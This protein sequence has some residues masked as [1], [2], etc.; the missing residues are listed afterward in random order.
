MGTIGRRA[1]APLLLHCRAPCSRAT[2]RVLLGA[3]QP[4]RCLRAARR[5]HAT[6]TPLPPVCRRQAVCAPPHAYAAVRGLCYPHLCAARFAPA[7]HAP[8]VWP[9]R[10]AAVEVFV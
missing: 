10:T 9:D 5:Y 6:R 8:S 1:A 7:C 3:A 2:A 4:D